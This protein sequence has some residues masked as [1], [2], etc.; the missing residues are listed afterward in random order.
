MG[1]SKPAKKKKAGGVKVSSQ[2]PVF[3]SIEDGD[4]DEFDECGDTAVHYAAVQGELAC[5]EA[6]AKAGAKL[7]VK[8]ND[9]ETPLQVASKSVKKRLKELVDAAEDADDA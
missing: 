5:V 6:L 7:E 8:D 3:G 1:P 4:K 9:G 2:T